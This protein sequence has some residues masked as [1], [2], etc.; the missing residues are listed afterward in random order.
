[1]SA[2]PLLSQGRLGPAGAGARG[3]ECELWTWSQTCL[4][5][6]THSLVPSGKLLALS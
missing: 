3:V 4:G 5:K 1:M 2:L 6:G